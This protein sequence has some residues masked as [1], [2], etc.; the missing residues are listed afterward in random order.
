MSDEFT[1]GDLVE[2]S[3]KP[4]GARGVRF[5]FVS[6]LNEYKTKVFLVDLKG[7]VMHAKAKYI[8]GVE[9]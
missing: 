3:G 9:P 1:L 5:R 8:K 6:Y 2:I 4:L 7:S